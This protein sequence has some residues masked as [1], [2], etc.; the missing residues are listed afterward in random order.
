MDDLKKLLIQAEAQ[1]ER[2]FAQIAQ[3]M[4]ELERITE[5]G[6]DGSEED[7][8]L[9]LACVHLMIAEYNRHIIEIELGGMGNV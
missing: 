8:H 3:L 5:E 7:A 1:R 4:P 9:M 2:N 6:P